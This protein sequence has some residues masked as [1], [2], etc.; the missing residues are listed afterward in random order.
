MPSPRPPRIALGPDE[1]PAWMRDAV[2]AGGGHVVPIDQADALIWA[3]PSNPRTL[4]AALDDAPQ[5]RWVQLP[6]AGVEHFAHLLTDERIWTCG[7]GAY[8]EPVAELALGLMLA[9]LRSIAGYAR[10]SSWSGESGRNLLSARVSILGGGGIATNLVRLLQPFDCH[11]TVVRRQAQA[12]PGVDEVLE[13]DRYFDALPDA[14][15]VVLAL[16]LVP[17]TDGIMSRNEFEAMRPHAWVVNVARGRHVVTDDLVWALTEG[18]IGG[19]ALDVTDPEP[20]PDDHPLWSLPNCIITP[21]V[22]N[23]DEMGIPLLGARITRNVAAWAHGDPLE[24][25]VDPELGF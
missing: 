21:H 4:E 1:P 18:T 9:G 15:V 19:A 22:G 10:A 2:I 6:H 7:K 23:T 8:A 12:M 13:A 17:E 16:P 3:D 20:L 25:L 24:G 11:V 14:D 5:I